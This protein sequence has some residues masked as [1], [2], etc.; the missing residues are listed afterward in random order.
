MYKIELCLTTIRVDH[1]NHN[2]VLNFYK[3]SEIMRMTYY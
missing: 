1:G 3:V 2:R